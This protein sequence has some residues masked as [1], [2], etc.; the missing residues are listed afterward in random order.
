MLILLKNLASLIKA[1]RN[2]NVKEVKKPNGRIFYFEYFFVNNN[3]PN[4]NPNDGDGANDDDA[5]N[6]A[7]GDDDANVYTITIIITN[8]TTTNN[9]NNNKTSVC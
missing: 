4:I 9:N 2:K 7:N 6:D 3:D 5:S 8:T 1:L